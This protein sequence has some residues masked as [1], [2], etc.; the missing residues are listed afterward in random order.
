MVL[1]FRDGSMYRVHFG[2]TVG[3]EI[4]AEHYCILLLCK[5]IKHQNKS[6]FYGEK[7]KL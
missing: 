2:N 1:N 5:N 6:L 7:L 4:N 3:S